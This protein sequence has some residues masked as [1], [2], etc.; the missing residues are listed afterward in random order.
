MMT[1][2]V[3]IYLDNVRM[4]INVEVVVMAVVVVIL[5]DTGILGP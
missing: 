3:M 1:T 5:A 2:I 4:I